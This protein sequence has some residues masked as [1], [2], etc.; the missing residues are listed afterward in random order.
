MTIINQVYT[1]TKAAAVVILAFIAFHWFGIIRHYDNKLNHIPYSIVESSS[2]NYIVDLGQEITND[3][4]HY[5]ALYD[6]LLAR[7]SDDTVT[8]K[9]HGYGGSVTSAILVINGIKETKA[10]VLGD[11]ESASYSAHG[12][13]A[14]TIAKENLKFHG[15]SFIM[16]HSV[17]SN[18]KPPRELQEA[19]AGRM[20]SECVSKGYMTQA[21]ADKMVADNK[22]EY[23]YWPGKPQVTP[24][25]EIIND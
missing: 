16:L 3:V 25:Q 19:T 7:S 18:R 2:G 20:L 22:V 17:Q 21:D 4:H 23:Y 24:L 10:K 13:I 1:L 11:V 9:L 8:F 15:Y 12:Y 5:K 14:C 6:F